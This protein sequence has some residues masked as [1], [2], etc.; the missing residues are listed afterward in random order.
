MYEG[1]I[2]FFKDRLSAHPFFKKTGLKP[3]FRQILR[4]VVPS[5]KQHPTVVL[6]VKLNRT[7]FAKVNG[8][9]KI[10]NELN[11]HFSGEQNKPVVEIHETVKKNYEDRFYDIRKGMKLT[12]E[13]WQ[14]GKR[15]LQ[16]TIMQQ[17]AVWMGRTLSKEPEFK[18]I[19]FTLSPYQESGGTISENGAVVEQWPDVGLAIHFG[20]EAVRELKAWKEKNA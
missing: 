8:A 13:D 6:T 5:G 17:V 9:L 3:E 11:K 18:S 16:K 14:E 7:H 12:E 20:E 19:N 4:E 10:L 2:E 1:E 15:D